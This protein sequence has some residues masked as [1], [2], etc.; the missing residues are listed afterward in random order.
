MVLFT[1]FVT[2]QERYISSVGATHTIQPETIMIASNEL[3]ATIG[4]G[5]VPRGFKEGMW[6]DEAS[7][8]PEATT[9]EGK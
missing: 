4:L 1:T 7:Q 9:E 6:R 8:L 5:D 3:P 2:P